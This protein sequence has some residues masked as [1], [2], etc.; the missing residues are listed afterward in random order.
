MNKVILIGRTTKE[1]VLK[2]TSNDLYFTQFTLAVAKKF[3]KEEQQADFINC[4]AWR[5][6][7]ELL[8]NYVEK[9]QLIAIEGSI[10][11]R[12][13]NDK[14]DVVHYITEVV[15]ENVE[16]LGSKPK[17]EEEKQVQQKQTYNN[18]KYTKK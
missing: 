10:Q 16:F 3:N 4:I 11:V 6:K 14:N 2:K 5:E 17:E 18:Q 9:G 7:A 15:V 13:Y 8:Y 12:S 1:L